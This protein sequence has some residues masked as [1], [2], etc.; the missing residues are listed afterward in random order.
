MWNS[1]Y[2][3]GS[4]SFWSLCHVTRYIFQ[5]PSRKSPCLTGMAKYTD[6][7]GCCSFC[8]TVSRHQ[9]VL[10]KQAN[11][12]L[13]LQGGEKDIV[14]TEQYT[15]IISVK[16]IYGPFWYCLLDCWS[17]LSKCI[18]RMFGGIQNL[19]RNWVKVQ[20]SKQLYKQYSLHF[21]MANFKNSWSS[22]F[23]GKCLVGSNLAWDHALS[24]LSLYVALKKKKKNAWSQV[25]SNLHWHYG[26]GR[27]CSK[28][29]LLYGLFLCVVT[30]RMAVKQTIHVKSQT[31][32][33]SV[34]SR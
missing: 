12:C 9:P 6:E 30:Q 3:S 33:K 31:A 24:L 23:F 17:I 32:D 22:C 34:H 10:W 16:V 26:P 25:R 20:P 18:M 15:H 8:Y 5:H 19:I 4:F 11:K 21:K 7:N 1:P 2:W 27:G 29:S 13:E 28:A 14:V